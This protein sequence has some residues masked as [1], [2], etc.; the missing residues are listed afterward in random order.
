MD[1]KLLTTTEVRVS[2]PLVQQ[3]L[4]YKEVKTMY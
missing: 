4:A 1:K 2:S 3:Y